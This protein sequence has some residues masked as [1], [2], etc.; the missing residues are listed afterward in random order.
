MIRL[1]LTSFVIAALCTAAHA[2]TTEPPQHQLS[3]KQLPDVLERGIDSY[4]RGGRNV[5]VTFWRNEYIPID[6][7]DAFARKLRNAFQAAEN[8]YKQLEVV[9]T[10]LKRPVSSSY[11]QYYLLFGYEYGVL[12][13]RFDVY[14]SRM[15]EQ[16]VE[17]MLTRNPDEILPPL[18][19]VLDY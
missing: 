7:R 13:V 8:D 2:Q 16:L 12:F 3:Y 11:V 18:R 9:E 14:D 4:K 15:G 19:E 5:A 17:C 6:K 1:L 10:I